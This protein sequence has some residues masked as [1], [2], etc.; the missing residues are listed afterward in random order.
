MA[1]AI[2]QNPDIKGIPVEENELK[3]SLLADDSTCFINGSDSSF[4]SLFD[5]IEIFSQSSGCRLNVSKSEAI[6]IG[7]KKG[8]QLYPFS[9]KGLKWNK[10]TFK[11]L[12]IHFSLNTKQLYDLNHMIKL[13]SIEN[14]LNCWRARNLSL[15]GKICVI[16]TLLLPQLLYFFSV[17]CIKLPN[18][19]FR[20]LNTI[21]F[22]FI[23]NGGNDRVKRQ[24]MCN[25]YSFGG[26]QMI[27]PYTFSMAQKMSWVKLLLDDNYESLWKSIEM[28]TLNNFSDKRDILW[29][30]YAPDNIL[31]KLTSSQLAESLQTWYIFRESLSKTEF[32][33]VFSSIG[34]CQCIWF[35]RNIRS[36]S[37]QYF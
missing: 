8:T 37:K 18:K 14:T 33:A 23:W 24:F 2:R 6:W 10:S 29:K 20:Q 31:N 3:I 34:S 36:K 16:K 5:T 32:N 19:I 25:D 22:K 1:L 21:L 30:T 7:S 4:K 27:D 12:G 15:V 26:L 28:S 35:N 17:L 13:K 9:D 11:T